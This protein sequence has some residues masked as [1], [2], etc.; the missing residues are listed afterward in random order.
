MAAAGALRARIR[1]TG[2]SFVPGIGLFGRL[3]NSWRVAQP[4]FFHQTPF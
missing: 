4:Q 2:P 3:K 1:K